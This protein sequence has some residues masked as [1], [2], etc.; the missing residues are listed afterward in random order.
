MDGKY[1]NPDGDYPCLV[2]KDPNGIAIYRVHCYG[3]K[4]MDDGIR[5]DFFNFHYWQ[6]S[7][8][9]EVFTEDP[10]KEPLQRILALSQNRRDIP[11]LFVEVSSGEIENI[12]GAQE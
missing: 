12:L 1:E 10:M 11:H 4:I 9:M 5:Y 6:Q 8:N 3:N 7:L 2:W